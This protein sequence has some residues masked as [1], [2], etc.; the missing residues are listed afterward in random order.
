MNLITAAF[1]WHHVVWHHVVWSPVVWPHRK[2]I[3]V[4]HTC[5]VQSCLKSEFYVQNCVCAALA[6]NF[7]VVLVDIAIESLNFNRKV[8]RM[9]WW[10]WVIAGFVL[11][12][13]ELVIPSGF[14][15]FFFGISGILV[16]LLLALGLSL[17]VWGQVMVFGFSALGFFLVSRR[18]L[19]N[20]AGRGEEVLIEKVV[21]KELIAPGRV[22]NGEFKGV[23]CRVHNVGSRTLESGLIYDVT[24]FD[25]ITVEVASEQRPSVSVAVV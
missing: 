22:G 15:I 23:A 12:M 5:L 21:V 3:L 18:V 8:N 14:F 20:K 10:F 11:L 16:G 2:A 25:G 19:M 1:V 13:L 24:R 7:S 6:L 4:E 9:F 17:P